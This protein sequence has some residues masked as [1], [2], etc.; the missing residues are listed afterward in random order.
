V[1]TLGEIARRVWYLLNRRRFDAA[2]TREMDAHRAMMADPSRFGNALRLREAS[3]DAWGWTWLD[4]VGRDIRI[5]SRSLRR[6]PGFTIV[7]IASLV[8]GLTLAVATVAVANAYLIRSLP[9]P[10]AQRLYHVMY[11]PPGPFEPGGLSALDWT[12]VQDVVELPVTASGETLYLPGE[13]SAQQLRGLRASRGFLQAL[14]V[15][16][17][18]GRTL[19]DEEFR[20]GADDAGMIGDNIW[21]TRFGGD[22]GVIGRTI[23]VETGEQGGETRTVRVT[24]VLPPGFWFGRESSAIVDMLLPLRTPA[25]TYMVRLREGVPVALAERRITEA[26]R[27]VATRVPTDWTGVHLESAHER[28]VRDV[29]PVLIGISVAAGLVLLIACVNVAVLVLLRALHRQKEMSIRVALGAGRWHIVRMLVAESGL[30]CG[31]SVAISVAVT[32]VALRALATMIET[33]LGRT[34]PGGVA[35]IGVDSTMVALLAVVGMLIALSLCVVPL[36]TPWRRRLADTLRSGGR[37]GTDGVSMR[38]LR[39]TL[40]GIELAG[41][42]VLLVGCGLMIRSVVQMTRTDLGFRP[43]RVIRA[44]T[45]VPARSYPDPPARFAFYSRVTERAAT[46]ARGRVALTTWPPFAESMAFPVIGDGSD[47]PRASAG[48]VAVGPDYFA[49]LGIPVREGRTFSSGDRVGGEPV[50]IVSE[51]LARRLWPGGDALG[52][53]LRAVEAPGQSEAAETWRT[54]VGVVGDVRQT[55]GD[56]E[57]GD[58]YVPFYQVPP[59]RYGTFYVETGMAAPAL[60]SALRTSLTETDPSALLRDVTSVVSENRQF[61]GT[62]FLMGML[63]TFAAFAAFLAVVGMYGVIAYAVLQRRR[64]FA[65]RIA[66]GATRATVTRLS[67]RGGGVVLALGLVAGVVASSAATRVLQN[68]LYGVPPFDVWTLVAASTLLGGAGL[69]AVWWPARRAS[70]VDP[71]T[72][73][74]DG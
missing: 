29:R 70:S 3:R 38:R 1:D 19:S 15:R 57:L 2:L 7:T 43:E 20:L 46:L 56:S 8:L 10:E 41:S 50:A 61:A 32:T 62:R 52:R 13:S 11:A 34:A 74:S 39:T 40:I 44:R 42:M 23:R 63:T 66:L 69:L 16:A 14:G 45:F 58:V 25:R 48:S 36:A 37:H 60:A 27:L 35:A 64:E 18:L 71:V 67:M 65:I 21:R 72:V 17:S 6:T 47:A 30:L 68:R 73:L 22:S 5:A 24:G 4:H 12:S 26:A 31:A 9:Y 53:R 54:V 55:Y 51:T 59:D 49:V 28:Y 33:Q